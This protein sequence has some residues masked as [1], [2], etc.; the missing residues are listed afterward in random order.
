MMIYCDLF[1]SREQVF[2]GDRGG[3]IGKDVKGNL[4]KS[5]VDSVIVLEIQASEG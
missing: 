2:A 3:L 4:S 1:A 5:W